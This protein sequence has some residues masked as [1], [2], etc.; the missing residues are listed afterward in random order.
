MK[1]YEEVKGIYNAS[2]KEFCKILSGSSGDSSLLNTWK[3]KDFG[4]GR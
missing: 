3:L 2:Y 4:L 1:K